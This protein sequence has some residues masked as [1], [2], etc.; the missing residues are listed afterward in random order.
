MPGSWSPLELPNL[1][2]TNYEVKSQATRRYNCIAWAA[3]EDFRWWWPD[4]MGKSYWPP[5]VTR[6]E[7]IPAFLE[8][9]QTLGFRLCTDGA[10]ETGIEKV[11][12]Y[13]RGQAGAEVPTHASLQ[14]KSGQ[15]T[16]KIGPFEDIHH[17]TLNGVSGPIY[18][19]VIRYLARPRRA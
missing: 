4:P 7:T 16:S 12:I 3:S 14:L 10:L 18:G 19:H 8:A 15:W 1:N 5:G 9:Y 2:A 17:E 6:A 11:A 13:G